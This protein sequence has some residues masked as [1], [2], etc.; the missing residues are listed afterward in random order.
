M[1]TYWTPAAFLCPRKNGE[2]GAVGQPDTRPSTPTS[3][4]DSFLG[5]SPSP[6]GGPS[7]SSSARRHSHPPAT[8][9]HPGLGATRSRPIRARN[10]ANNLR[11]TAT[12]AIWNVTALERETTLAPILISFSRR[13]VMD[14]VRTARGNAS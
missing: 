9:D 13:V 1:N 6:H 8:N 3:L 2:I 10:A 12:S 4:F 14:H 5:Q 7:P 11:G